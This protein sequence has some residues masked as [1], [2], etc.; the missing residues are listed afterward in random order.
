MILECYEKFSKVWLHV[1]DYS[2][3]TVI[4]CDSCTLCV[5][6]MQNEQHEEAALVA[7]NSPKVC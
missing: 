4:P 3:C 7:A 1:D 6:L 2:A 5:Q